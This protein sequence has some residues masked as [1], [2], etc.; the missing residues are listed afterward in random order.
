MTRFVVILAYF[1][2]KGTGNLLLQHFCCV[3][4]EVCWHLGMLE[5][6]R[7]MGSMHVFICKVNS[8]TANGKSLSEAQHITNWLYT[9]LN[10]PRM[11]QSP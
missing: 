11:L 1:V 3:V 10:T 8:Y 9:C 7:T 4:G 6:I 2:Q 5:M